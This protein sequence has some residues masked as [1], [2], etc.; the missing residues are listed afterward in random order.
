MIA[1]AGGSPRGRQFAAQHADT[2]VAH[3]KGVAA[4]KAYRDDVRGR[5]T[6]CGRDPDRCKV[7]FLVAPI[8]GQTESEAQ[9]RRQMRLERARQQIPQRL[10]HLGKVTNI[11]FGKFDLNRPLGELTTNGHQQTLEQFTVRRPARHCAS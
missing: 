11:D 5:M 1:Q 3:T 2:I 9:D 7:L 10:A 8:L 4:A 6:A